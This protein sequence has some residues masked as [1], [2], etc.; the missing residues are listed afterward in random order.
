MR[1]GFERIR[2]AFKIKGAAPEETLRGLVEQSRKRSAVYD[3][4][5]KGTQ[6]TITVNVG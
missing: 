5:T 6:V 2:V 1:N 3:L 4:L